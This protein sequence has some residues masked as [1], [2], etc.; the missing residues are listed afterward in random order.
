MIIG[1]HIQNWTY[2]ET[3]EAKQAIMKALFEEA[4]LDQAIQLV[5]PHMK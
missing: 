2:K 5:T 1:Q 3:L 4:D